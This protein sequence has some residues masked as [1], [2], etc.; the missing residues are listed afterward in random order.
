VK[1]SR[2]FSLMEL[3]IVL[4]IAGILAAVVLPSF[5]PREVDASWYYEK[6]KAAIRYAQRQAVAQRR[7]VYVVVSAGAISLC[8]DPAC[9]SPVSDFATGTA[10]VAAAPSGVAVTPMTFSFNGLGR[11]SAGTTFS[12]GA[13]PVNVVAE[14]GYVP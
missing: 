1:R 3:V 5:N 7:T 9:A 6:A 4:V 12:V 14:T 2:G 13:F 10:Y 8:Y 11:P